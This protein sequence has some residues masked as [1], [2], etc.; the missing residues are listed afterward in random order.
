M[1]AKILSLL[2]I[3][4]F[5]FGMLHASAVNE[6]NV[7]KTAETLEQPQVEKTT[8]AHTS[9]KDAFKI[10]F[11]MPLQT[12][13]GHLVKGAAK[14]A[15]CVGCLATTYILFSMLHKGLG[16]NAEINPLL[17]PAELED[18]AKHY[19]QDAEA[20]AILMLAPLLEKINIDASTFQ[21]AF[22]L[23]FAGP[24][25]LWAA[26][27]LGYSAWDSF[28]TALSRTSAPKVAQERPKKPARGDTA[29][30]QAPVVEKDEATGEAMEA[31]NKEIQPE[32]EQ[33]P[34]KEPKKPRYIL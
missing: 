8:T 23:T 13:L 31:S 28:K 17:N 25:T 29:A 18:L 21:A 19:N 24:S 33:A 5:A 7:Q 27:R 3:H 14:L 10:H 30:E 16:L 12:R 1:K 9:Q 22:V 20:S 34:S 6:T 2:I 26:Y 15:A 11:S 32:E 4:A